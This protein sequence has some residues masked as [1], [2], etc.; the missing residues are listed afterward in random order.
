MSYDEDRIGLRPSLPT[1]TEEEEPE[2]SEERR[3][4]SELGTG[5][6]YLYKRSR[7]PPVAEPSAP[8]SVPVLPSM[9]V[10]P[11]SSDGP[12]DA[13]PGTEELSAEEVLREWSNEELLDSAEPDA[14]P[15]H[16]TATK[17]GPVVRSVVPARVLPARPR[18]RWP[19][20]LATVVG[21]TTLLALVAL[22]LTLAPRL[23]STVAGP[24][25]AED[26]SPAPAASPEAT[27]TEP[28]EKA[29]ASPLDAPDADDAVA[30]PN[31][32][33][34][35]A[36]TMEPAPAEASPAEAEPR[37]TAEAEAPASATGPSPSSTAEPGL[38]PLPPP[39]PVTMPEP[40]ADRFAGDVEERRA[41]LR[42]L[43]HR[44]HRRL[45][46]EDLNGAESDWRWA[47][48]LVPRD[49]ASL[50][51]LARVALA[52]GRFGE[53]VGWLGRAQEI[54]GDAPENL[55]LIARIHEDLGHREEA[56]EAY[57]RA[58]EAITSRTR[59]RELRARREA[60]MS[61]AATR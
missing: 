42:V 4:G 43:R 59:R 29:S 2:V 56:V 55:A 44:A 31:E 54:S 9:P 24:P 13:P 33:P 7:P 52:R 41:R 21:V 12:S 17:S 48:R 50:R 60:L 38:R 18:R 45:L 37:P 32:P 57:G 61:P 10:S 40:L 5:S 58:L 27:G 23:L 39:E 3:S 22:G 34:A 20:I 36:A 1:P 35:A 16:P 30:P 47:L 6:V 15:L 53:A 28:P 49:T 8:T 26:P 19:V 25:S 46:R 14:I 51:G 11:P